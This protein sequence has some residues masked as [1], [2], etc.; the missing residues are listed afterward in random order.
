[1]R[2]VN[3]GS[4]EIRTW[5]KGLILLFIANFLLDDLTKI[6]STTF[7][8]ILSKAL[9]P[10]VACILL[11]RLMLVKN[12]SVNRLI[13]Y[14]LFFS[15]T[16]ASFFGLS[17]TLTGSHSESSKVALYGLSFYSA[18]LAYIF[19]KRQLTKYS[20][21]VASNPLLLITGPIVSR[22]GSIKYKKFGN[23]FSY[24]APF[25][26]LGVFLHQ[27][28]ATPLTECFDI[29]EKTDVLSVL[30]FAFIF[31]IFVYANFA[32]LSLIIYGLTGIIGFKVTLNFKQPFSSTNVID[33]WKGWHISISIILRELFLKPIKNILGT[34][35]AILFVFL[36]SALWHGVSLNFIFWGLFHAACFLLT[37][38]LLNNKLEVISTIVLLIA[39]PFA[40]ILSA[41]S[42]TSRLLEKLHFHYQDLE[43]VTR[44]GLLS[45][46][47][48][49]SLVLG[50]SF[51]IVE[52]SLKNCKYFRERR[53]KFYRL[54]YVQLCLFTLTLMLISTNSGIVYAVY[55]Q[56]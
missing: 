31:E 45:N 8:A 47:A 4:D 37:I 20:P 6:D 23:R 16:F 35:I 12:N 44:L 27:V 40:R 51:I 39:V 2:E 21:F 24:Y 22:F 54:P 18:S 29:I 32:G 42:D 11:C 7:F 19:A 56:R 36:S 52:F 10:L 43:I 48:K 49:L 53:Y 5:V 3:F 15:I 41:D 46:T 14:I 55:G 9:I 1:V 38:N 26:I 17:K 25:V 13:P 34:N 28:I 30:I 50:L 33:F